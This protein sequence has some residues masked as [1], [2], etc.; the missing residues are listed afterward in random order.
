MIAATSERLGMR[1]LGANLP[2]RPAA[3][4]APSMIAK[5]ITDVAS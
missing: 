3:M 1:Q 5:S 2:A 4:S